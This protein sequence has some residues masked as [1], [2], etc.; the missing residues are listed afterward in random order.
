MKTPK[1]N[2]IISHCLHEAN[3]NV[4]SIFEN[5]DVILFKSPIMMGL[6]DKIK[7]YV[8]N[9]QD[10]HKTTKSQPRK[11]VVL[12][13]TN[14]G[15]IETVERIYAVFRR[16]YEEVDFIIPNYAYSAG[17]IL[18]LS[19]DDI[20]MNYYSVLGPIDPQ[21]PFDDGHY[22]P[23]IGYL[24]KFDEL[25]KTINK[26]E[27][28]KK[29]RAELAYLIKRFDPAKLFY[30]EQSKDHSQTLLKEWLPKHKFKNWTTTKT[31]K[32]KVTKKYKE[33]RARNIAEILAEPKRW[34]SHGRGIGINDL[35]SE[36]I[37]L[38]VNNYGD[39]DDLNKAVQHYYDLFVDFCGRMGIKAAIHGSIGLERVL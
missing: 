33:D 29:T 5:A 20:Y 6:D 4:S 17:T 25:V 28:G 9:I 15:H 18:V 26:D 35:G 14:G 7:E 8:E 37:N 32:M 23:G 30:I 36:E 27:T 10:Q 31:R 21:L 22:L 12:I 13:E 16:Y 19:G 38:I 34:H 2:D 24:H 39:N 3:K 11:L 1:S